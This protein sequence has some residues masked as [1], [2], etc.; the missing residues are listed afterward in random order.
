MSIVHIEKYAKI[1]PQINR[2]DICILP[3]LCQRRWKVTHLLE[4]V[5]SPFTSSQRSAVASQATLGVLCRGSTG[6]GLLWT[7]SWTPAS[8][9]AQVHSE[10]HTRS[11][12]YCFTSGVHT[13][14]F[15]L[16]ARIYTN[17]WTFGLS[18]RCYFCLKYLSSC[19][20]IFTFWK[21]F[22][23]NLSLKC[24]RSVQMD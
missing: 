13:L 17:S 9:K 4:A 23:D 11:F 1:R 3:A 19:Y 22:V 10:Q 24:V 12:S 18:H 21:C 20:V 2:Q 6:C 8:Q 7:S 16:G 5:D 15:M 14:E